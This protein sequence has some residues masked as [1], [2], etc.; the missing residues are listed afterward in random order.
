M[1]TTL[2]IVELVIIGFQVLVWV[3]LLLGLDWIPFA[4]L[5]DWIPLVGVLAL[6]LA[7]TLGIVFDRFFGFFTSKIQKKLLNPDSHNWCKHLRFILPRY[8]R[9]S[10]YKPDEAKKKR[11]DIMLKHSDAHR[12][13]ENIVRQIRL[14]R[15]TYINTLI[16]F[17]ICC[18]K[19]GLSLPTLFILSVVFVSSLI[20]W[21]WYSGEY[22]KAL[23]GI[24]KE[25]TKNV[26]SSQK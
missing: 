4:K 24:Y 5:K 12:E 6:A 3:A 14:L 2:I 23:D 21:R 10:N 16:I 13:L 11:F 26:D 17:I 15:A 25:A 7:Y 9:T 8:I 1:G 19:F 18:F 20:T 22:A